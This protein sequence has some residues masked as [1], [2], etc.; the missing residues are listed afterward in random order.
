[1]GRR[2]RVP[3]RD[4]GSS[5]GWYER[6]SASSIEE[7]IK[8]M[9]GIVVVH[10][11]LLLLLEPFPPFRSV[12]SLD[13]HSPLGTFH[14]GHTHLFYLFSNHLLSTHSYSSPFTLSPRPRSDRPLVTL[15]Q[16]PRSLPSPTSPST[17]S[18]DYL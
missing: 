12:L 11:L 16:H 6:C 17:T 10:S 1:V 5:F 14:F 3:R 7:V 15:Y 8:T 2:R 4:M 18:H 13:L 9:Q